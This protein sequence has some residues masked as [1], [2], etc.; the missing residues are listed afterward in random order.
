M[1]NN[2]NISPALAKN[3]I[4][5][6][7]NPQQIKTFGDQLVNKAKDKIISVA[8]G[9]VQELEIQIEEIVKSSVQAGIN[10]NI[11]LKRLDTLLKEKQRTQEQYDD[12]VL[13]EN[14][15]Y[16]NQIDSFNLQIK[17]IKNDINNIKLDPLKKIKEDRKKRKVPSQHSRNY[18]HCY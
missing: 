11:V 4:E 1:P 12:A 18:S 5:L 14:E 17:K 2:I 7:K 10:H 3:T 9:K 8:L 6:A 13:A 16:K 15:A